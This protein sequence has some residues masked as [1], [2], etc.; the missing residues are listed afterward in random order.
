MTVIEKINN[1]HHIAFSNYILKP[2]DGNVLLFKAKERIYFVDD[3]AY[4]G[5]KKY[6]RNGVKVYDVPG[7]HKTMF[8]HPNVDELG[9]RLQASLDE[10]N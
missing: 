1:A 5:W 6:A 4:L 7:D 3:F 10:L 8:F 2:F 9:L